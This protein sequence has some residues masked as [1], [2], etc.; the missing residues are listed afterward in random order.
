MVFFLRSLWLYNIV[1]LI[2]S[3][4]IWYWGT[5]KK[6]HAFTTLYQTLW[7]ITKLYK[8]RHSILLYVSN[9]SIEINQI[10]LD[11]LLPSNSP[12][13]CR[14]KWKFC[15]VEHKSTR[16]KKNYE[17]EG[18]TFPANRE[19][20]TTWIKLL[21]KAPSPYLVRCCKHTYGCSK[22]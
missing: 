20:N 18:M 11:C 6:M 15:H 1:L 2:S 14:R 7:E 12:P 13:A 3:P 10:H 16:E 8:Q 9:I 5:H 4:Q 17:T 21:A 22:V 19:W